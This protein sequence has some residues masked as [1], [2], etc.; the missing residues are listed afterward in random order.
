MNKRQKQ[1][2]KTYFRKRTIS[3]NERRHSQYN[4]Y[5]YS[6]H[7]IIYMLK[8]DLNRKDITKEHVFNAISYDKSIVDYIPYNF[9]DGLN[10]IQIV[11]LLAYEHPELIDVFSDKALRNLDT[12]GVYD[13]LTIQPHM[14]D[15]LP[16]ENLNDEY[17][18]MVLSKRPELIDKLPLEKIKESLNNEYSREYTLKDLEK[19]FNIQPQLRKEFKKRKII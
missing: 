11:M 6:T 13:L 17:V 1:L 14:I 5:D 8:N 18:I 19:L 15:R 9:F 2:I 10:N 16:L 4:P 7:E 3:Y 12:V